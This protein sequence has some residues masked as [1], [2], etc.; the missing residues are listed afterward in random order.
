MRRHVHRSSRAN[1][2]NYNART[3]IDDAYR[4][5]HP[6]IGEVAYHAALPTERRRLHRAVATA[7]QAHPRFALTASDAAGE[8]ALHLDRGG[9]EAAAF[10][11]LFAAA[12]SAERIAP[13]TCLAHLERI[14]ELW[15]QHATPA[16]QPPLVARLWEAATPAHQ[17]QLVPRLWQAADLASATGHNERAVTLAR[18]ALELGDPPEGRAWAYERLGG[19]QWSSGSIEESAETYTRAA[20]ILET[21]PERRSEETPESSVVKPSC[22]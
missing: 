16:H 8:L 1:D 14:F 6:L 7:L 12:D 10:E 22:V 18:R 21:A 4:V 13:A 9:D 17:P 2:A 3:A 20:A 5:R 19:F 15:E 11:A